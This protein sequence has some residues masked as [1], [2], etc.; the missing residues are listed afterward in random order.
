MKSFLYYTFPFSP[1]SIF[2]LLFCLLLLT[3][4]EKE[5]DFEYHDV[6]PQLVVEAQLS[7]R[8]STVTL[9]ETTPMD[10]PIDLTR[11]TDASVTLTDLTDGT[12]LTLL[13]DVSGVYSDPTPG[14]AGHEY[15]VDIDRDGRRYSSSGVMLTPT[16]IT[17]LEFQWIKM[18]YDYVAVLNV[19]FKDLPGADDCYWIRLYRNGQP[20]F[21]DLVNKSFAS[22]GIVSEAIMTS[23]RD[24]DEEDDKDVLL[25][26]DVVTVS[27]TPISRSL[28]DYFT[29]LS[30]DSNGPRMFDGDFCLGYF[31]TAPSA[32]S[33]ITYRPDEFTEFK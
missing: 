18:P 15:R 2:T 4:C 24:T 17:T 8:G 14:I 23:R 30:A 20:Y 19:E 11:L 3:S 22:E 28:Y 5:L 21:W 6:S 16:E 31:L 1:L 13:P 25:N 7:D 27:V 9:T 29:A 12:T 32:T 33:S 10:E 26:G